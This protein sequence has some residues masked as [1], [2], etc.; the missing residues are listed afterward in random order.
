[1]KERQV[2]LLN[3]IRSVAKELSQYQI[4]YWQSYSA[5]E[6]WQFWVQVLMI[7]IPLMILVIF[8]DR[9][10]TILLGFFGLNYHLWFSYVNSVGIGLGLWEYPYHTIPPLPSF[11]LDA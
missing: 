1:M 2:E 8:I 3:K 10:K 11:S 6:T 5:Y 4:D 7:I 9:N